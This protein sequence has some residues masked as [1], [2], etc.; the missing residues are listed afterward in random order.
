LA[1]HGKP[2]VDLPLEYSRSTKPPVMAAFRIHP[3]SFILPRLLA[4]V[5]VSKWDTRTERTPLRYRACTVVPPYQ[6]RSNTLVGRCTHLCAKNRL[7]FPCRSQPPR[8]R[9]APTPHLG[10]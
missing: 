8:C 1:N 9:G 3:T 10:H 7:R 6:H 2:Q 5:V 4:G